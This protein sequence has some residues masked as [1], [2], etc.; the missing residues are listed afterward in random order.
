MRKPESSPPHWAITTLPWPIHAIWTWWFAEC[1]GAGRDIDAEFKKT[2]EAT[3]ERIRALGQVQLEDGTMQWVESTCCGGGNLALGAQIESS[4]AIGV[5]PLLALAAIDGDPASVWRPTA[6]TTPWLKI[7][8]Q[9]AQGIGELR[10]RW[11]Q[12]GAPEAYRIEGSEDGENW[13]KLVEVSGQREGAAVSE[14]QVDAAYVRFL[15][16]SFMEVPAHKASGGV[17]EIEVFADPDSPTS[18]VAGGDD[19]T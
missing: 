17:A 1:C 9:D 5:G 11:D 12:A 15:R 19:R 4:P 7:E 13:L 8:L 16:L 6:G 2:D 18:A 10:I 14:H 3:D